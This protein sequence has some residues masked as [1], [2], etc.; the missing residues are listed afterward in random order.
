MPWF[1]GARSDAADGSSAQQKIN[2][3]W[4]IFA[5]FGLGL[6]VMRWASCP[7][8]PGATVRAI[9]QHEVVYENNSSA[10]LW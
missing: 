6:S 4:L 7:I 2:P 1:A 8:S 10:S 3:V 9:V 5:L